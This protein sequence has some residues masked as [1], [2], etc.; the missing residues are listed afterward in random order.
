MIFSENR[1]R[2]FGT[3]LWRG[4]THGHSGAL[5]IVFHGPP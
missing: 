2:L 4:G 3:V 5:Q 1:G